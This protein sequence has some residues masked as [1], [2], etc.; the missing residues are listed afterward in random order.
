M[1][2]AKIRA[3]GNQAYTTHGNAGKRERIHTVVEEHGFLLQHG[4]EALQQLEVRG[5]KADVAED[6]LCAS[7]HVS[8]APR[9]AAWEARS[10]EGTKQTRGKNT[11]TTCCGP[12]SGGGGGC[13]MYVVDEGLRACASKHVRGRMIWMVRVRSFLPC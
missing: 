13:A 6:E 10:R 2:T 4:E 3:R 7:A 12:P 11:L 1:T 8:T 9:Y 5:R